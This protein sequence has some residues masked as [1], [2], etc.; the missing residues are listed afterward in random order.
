MTA[1]VQADSGTV[2]EVRTVTLGDELAAGRPAQT[3]LITP[4]SLTVASGAITGWT[5]D[6]VTISGPTGNP[7]VEP[8]DPALYAWL[9]SPAWSV[10]AGVDYAAA[11]A[12]G[13]EPQ[14]VALVFSDGTVTEVTSAGRVAVSGTAPVSGSAYLE[15]RWWPVTAAGYGVGVYDEGTYGG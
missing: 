4:A 6:N 11:I 9:R 15:L 12:V 8:T 3:N 10:T 2:V 7:T 13:P 1:I 5:G 14:T